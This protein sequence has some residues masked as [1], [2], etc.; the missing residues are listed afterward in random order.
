M[1][2]TALPPQNTVNRSLAVAIWHHIQPGNPHGPQDDLYFD[3][4]YVR[5]SAETATR[6]AND[7]LEHGWREPRNEQSQRE[8]IQGLIRQA[9]GHV[10]GEGIRVTS[11]ELERLLALAFDHGTHAERGYQIEYDKAGKPIPRV[12]AE[13][14]AEAG[15]PSIIEP[16]KDIVSLVSASSNETVDMTIRQALDLNLLM[17]IVG[18]EST[19]YTAKGDEL[20]LRCSC[21]KYDRHVGVA[22]GIEDLAKQFREEHLFQVLNAAPL[23]SLEDG[24]YWDGTYEWRKD[25][26]DWTPLMAPGGMPPQPQRKGLRRIVKTYEEI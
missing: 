11:D 5:D 23:A 7:L 25:G 26:D 12:S 22:I 6:I 1:A 2:K 19:L 24:T 18:H 16:A 4:P 3:M 14:L 17:G 8:A 15:P 9:A 20:W 10:T 13:K 21:G